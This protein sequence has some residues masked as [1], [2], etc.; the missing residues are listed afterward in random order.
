MD[1]LQTNFYIASF[2]EV[3]KNVE[4]PKTTELS[5]QCCHRQ[6]TRIT[7]CVTCGISTCH[8]CTSADHKAENGH[9][10]I[11][12]TKTETA[13]IKE[14]NVSYCSLTQNKKNLKI[15]ESEMALLTAAKETAINDMENFRKL[16]HEELEKRSNEL[17]TQLL[18]RFKEKQN[19][20]LDKQKDIKEENGLLSDTLIQAKQTAKAGNLAKL[21]PISDS[22]QTVNE[23][24]QSIYSNLDLGENYLVFDSNKGSDEFNKCLGSLG[25]ICT[26][27]FLPSTIVFRSTG[28]KAGHKTKLT[29]DIY[30]HHGDA[31][32]ISSVPLSL[33]MTDPTDTE[34][35]THLCKSDSECTVTF[36]PQI[37]GLH[38]VSWMFLGKELISELTHIPVSSNSPVLKFGKSGNGGGAFNGPWSIVIDGSNCLYVTDYVNKSVQKFTS[39]GEL[40]DHFSVAVHEGHTVCD[41]AIDL[42]KGLLFCPMAFNEGDSL[43]GTDTILV[44]DL[45]GKLQHSYTLSDGRRAFS[46]AL[47]GQGNIMLSSLQKECLLKVDKQCNYISSLGQLSSPGDIAVDYNGIIIVPDEAND[48]VYIFNPDGSERLKFGASGT[49]KGHMKE[50]RGVATDGEYILVCEFENNRVQVFKYDGTFV[51]MIESIED[52]LKGPCGLALTSDGYVYVADTGHHCVKKFKYRD[53]S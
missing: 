4:P 16:A 23:K 26:K 27:G 41:I 8:D 12:I 14:L 49:E 33:Q 2:Q 38:K 20:L 21:K 45:E 31:L 1:G 43:D 9:V 22:L 44:F 39:G 5:F 25:Q 13:Y 3:S 24:A 32:P 7:F 47:D 28:A 36:T 40:L 48:C 46:I 15:I 11:N 30:D 19:A 17:M 34:L 37:S 53:M 42:H 18:D 35:H 52:P 10:I 29:V 50:P 51:S 6:A